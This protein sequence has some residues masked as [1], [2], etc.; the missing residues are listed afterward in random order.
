M[1]MGVFSRMTGLSQKA[2]RIYDR[3][4]LLSPAR[5]NRETRY[6]YYLPGQ[7]PDAM[8]IKMMRQLGISLDDIKVLMEKRA[9]DEIND[10]LERQ[11][12]KLKRQIWECERAL[13]F[14][15]QLMR[16]YDS[17]LNMYEVT[18]AEFAGCVVISIR[19]EV[20]KKKFD[21]K[22]EEHR[23]RLTAFLASSGVSLAGH[24]MAL[25]HHEEFSP[26]CFDLE[27]CMPV[28]RAVRCCGDIVCRTLVGASVIKTTHAGS[29][30]GIEAAYGAL[31]RW[32]ENNSR[33]PLRPMME[34][35]V[36]GPDGVPREDCRTE[37][38]WPVSGTA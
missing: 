37:V 4:G 31:L 35:Y 22:V 7:L 23:N 8:R 25:L 36:A 14:L 30:D 19:E 24:S 17:V 9:P 12:D 28:E 6:S 29:Y 11:A 20:A 33:T 21:E 26:K 27:T 1:K 10:F 34:I 18:E 5:V 16:D 32:M 13:L 38:V 3:S 2:L 15:E